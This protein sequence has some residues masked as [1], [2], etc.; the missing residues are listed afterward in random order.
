MDNKYINIELNTDY[1]HAIK[2][3]NVF[4]LCNV[5]TS[6]LRKKL[7]FRSVTDIIQININYGVNK[8]SY[9]R[10]YV[11]YDKINKKEFVRLLKI[12]EINVDYY[13]K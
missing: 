10:E 4:Y 13:K 9:D 8:K 6:V 3:R 7:D 5:A 12:K 11:L 2:R 1:D